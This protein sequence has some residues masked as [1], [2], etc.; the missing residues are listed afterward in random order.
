MRI[1]TPAE[2]HAG[3][4]YAEGLHIWLR[5]IKVDVV[6]AEMDY[7]Y[8]GLDE[9]KVIKRKLIAVDNDIITK[10]AYKYVMGKMGSRQKDLRFK[11]IKYAVLCDRTRLADFSVDDYTTTVGSE[12]VKP[13]SEV[14]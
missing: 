5:K 3:F 14:W 6:L 4:F 7:D 9:T 1:I 13:E 2:N 11:D 12:I 8:S 10:T